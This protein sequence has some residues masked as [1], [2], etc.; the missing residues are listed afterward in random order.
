MD[1]KVIKFTFNKR[2]TIM[3][4]MMYLFDFQAS[5][6]LFQEVF[7]F[8]YF[9]MLYLLPI[10]SKRMVASIPA[11]P[12]NISEIEIITSSF[13]LDFNVLWYA[14]STT[15]LIERGISL[16]IDSMIFMVLLNKMTIRSWKAL[17]LKWLVILKYYFLGAPIVIHL[18]KPLKCISGEDGAYYIENSAT[19]CYSMTGAVTTILTIISILS[20]SIISYLTISSYF[21]MGCKTTGVFSR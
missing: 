14:S 8:G 7:E 6:P 5:T 21:E 9:Q 1:E 15:Y 16:T 17:P 3:K 10:I 13:L 19:R 12:K 4:T 11:L 18:I 20:Q 2:T